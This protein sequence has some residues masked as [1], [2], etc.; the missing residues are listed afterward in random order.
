MLVWITGASSGIGAAI[1]KELVKRDHHVILT[2]RRYERLKKLKEALAGKVTI[3]SLDVR[4]EKEVELFVEQCEKEIGSVDVLINNAG[5]LLE[6]IPATEANIQKWDTMID[7]N[8][9]GVLYCT[10]NILPYMKRRNRGYII[11]MG[12][13]S[14]T[15]PSAGNPV[16][17][18]TK[19]FL[20]QFSL[21]LRGNLIGS[22]IRV[23]NIEPG[24]T[25]T[26]LALVC[27]EGN[28]EQAKTIYSEIDPLKPEDIASIV[29]WCLETPPHVNI[30]RIE[31]M[32]ITQA[33]S[34]TKKA[35]KR[36]SYE[37]S[38]LD[39]QSN[40]PSGNPANSNFV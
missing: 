26:E 1:A 16:Y 6:T 24:I 34:G 38:F 21:S 7:T 19:A 13:I 40:I 2:A 32:P 29:S 10:K 9:K 15:Y 35:K 33:A 3:F 22:A 30:N 5:L 11:N 28:E 20:K 17:A 31:V 4:K 37:R 14:G 23:T 8:I 18:S 39:N 25:E 12:S 36:G 27:F